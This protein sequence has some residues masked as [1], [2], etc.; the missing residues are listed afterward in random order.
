[1]LIGMAAIAVACSTAGKPVFVEDTRPLPDDEPHFQTTNELVVYA[2]GAWV[3]TTTRTRA[4]MAPRVDVDLG[5]LD[6]ARLAAMKPALGRARFRAHLPRMNCRGMPE[7]H[8]VF[9]SPARGLR[10]EIDAPCREALDEG[11]AVLEQCVEAIT[12]WSR[13]PDWYGPICRGED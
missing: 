6:P 1:V 9:T 2:S 8:V 5:C 4:G 13:D 3:R 12:D 7:V 11:T 10:A